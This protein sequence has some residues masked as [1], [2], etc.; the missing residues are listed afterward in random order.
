M[1]V[2]QTIWRNK[3]EHKKPSN[4]DWG[5]IF[6]KLKEITDDRLWRTPP[7]SNLTVFTVLSKSEL[8]YDFRTGKLVWNTGNRPLSRLFVLTFREIGGGTKADN[9]F[10]NGL[11]NEI[12]RLISLSMGSIF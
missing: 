12:W 9:G 2:Y 4:Q 10:S 6:I 8:R 5:R 3:N 11:E 7:V 1:L